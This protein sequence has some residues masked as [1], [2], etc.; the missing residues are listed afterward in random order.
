MS[1]RRLTDLAPDVYPLAQ[2][3]MVLCEARKI[4]VLVTCTLRPSEEQAA[5]FAQGR[6]PLAV[7]NALRAQAGLPA[8]TDKDN[9]MIVTRARPG[10]SLHETG[11]AFDV[12]PMD[13]GKPVWND[14]SVLWQRLGEIGKEVGLEWAGLWECFREYPHFQKR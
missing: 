9:A 6:N 5:L 7:V 3:F 8:I 2:R 12:V 4:D 11:R 1:S 13:G 10:Q 14:R